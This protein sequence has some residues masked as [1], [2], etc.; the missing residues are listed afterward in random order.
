MSGIGLCVV[1]MLAVG[2]MRHA[3]R[4]RWR[5]EQ[6]AGLG[7]PHNIAAC[8]L[9]RDVQADSTYTWLGSTVSQ[10]AGWLAELAPAADESLGRLGDLEARAACR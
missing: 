9:L 5:K 7:R 8:A 2:P 4:A 1:L 6:S 3:T 10:T